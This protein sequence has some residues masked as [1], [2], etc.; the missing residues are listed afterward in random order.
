VERPLLR[1]ENN[2]GQPPVGFA[3]ATKVCTRSRDRRHQRMDETNS[4]GV[5][6]DNV[7][8]HSGTDALPAVSVKRS[9]D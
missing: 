4:F 8:L 9:R 3:S 7:G 1:I 6:L 2:V 5:D